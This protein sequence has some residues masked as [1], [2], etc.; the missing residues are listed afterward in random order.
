MHRLLEEKRQ[1]ISTLCS[2]Y[3]VKRLEAFGS[4]ARG[5]DFDSAH[6][7]ADFLVEFAPDTDMAA[8][9]GLQARLSELLGR[10]VDLVDPSSIRNPYVRTSIN[11]S[12]EVIYGA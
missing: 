2:H 1:E 11:R 5:E 3:R 8:Y 7:D 9:F 10:P 12:R 6:S 4:A